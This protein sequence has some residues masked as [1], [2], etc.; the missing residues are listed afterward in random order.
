MEEAKESDEITDAVGDVY[1]RIKELRR[2]GSKCVQ[3]VQIAKDGEVQG[4]F[5]D[6]DDEDALAKFDKKWNDEWTADGFDD[7]EE[8]ISSVDSIPPMPTASEIKAQGMT[9][10]YKDEK[11]T[12]GTTKSKTSKTSE[13]EFLSPKKM[14]T[15]D[16][17]SKK[18]GSEFSM[19]QSSIEVKPKSGTG[20]PKSPRSGGGKRGLCKKTGSR[21][22]ISSMSSLSSLK[23]SEIRK[24]KIHVNVEYE[25]M[26]KP[27]G[28]DQ[29][30]VRERANNDHELLHVK[31]EI[32]PSKQQ[33]G[34]KTSVTSPSSPNPPSTPTSPTSQSSPTSP[35]SP[36][37]LSSPT[38]SESDSETKAKR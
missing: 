6:P 28:G 24:Q 34:S 14:S 2:I 33:L 13:T 23:G 16:F 27:V 3:T 18:S 21:S 31:M 4:I 19:S 25:E 29:E 15:S 32:V 9:T 35:S 7:S 37:S 11:V 26:D 38:S 30:E 22:S 12:S 8:T 10:E 5:H 20:S 1:L 17:T 36:T